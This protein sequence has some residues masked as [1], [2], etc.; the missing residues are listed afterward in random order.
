MEL[1]GSRPST[2]ACIATGFAQLG[3]VLGVTIISGLA[4]GGSMLLLVVPGVIVSAMLYV[5]VPVTLAVRLGID[6]AMKRSRQLTYG[7]KGDI[8]LI[9][10]LAG[11]V[12][13]G[14]ELCVYSQLGHTSGLIWREL[15]SGLTTMFFAVT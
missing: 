11:A 6:A 13:L 14:L 12:G 4:I 1:Q 5:V 10:L 2:R 9:L 15:F 3:R 7:Y 8:F